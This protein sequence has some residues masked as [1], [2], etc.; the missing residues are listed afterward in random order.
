MQKYLTLFLLALGFLACNKNN[1]ETYIET[2]PTIYSSAEW[3]SGPVRLFTKSGEI[4]DNSTIAELIQ[5]RDVGKQLYFGT[6]GIDSFTYQ[7]RTIRSDS[8]WFYMMGVPYKCRMIQSWNARLLI[9]RDTIGFYANN[10]YEWSPYLMQVRNGFSNYPPLYEM[11]SDGAFPKYRVQPVF[12][13]QRTNTGMEA[14]F[15]NSVLIQP[16]WMPVV[17][18]YV[19]TLNANGYSQLAENDTLLIQERVLVM[20]KRNW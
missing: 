7:L 1:H 16:N 12:P 18:N 11:L 13:M 17:Q 8:V 3:R 4:T 19:T 6:Q 5:R 2:F 15:I 10:S 14:T 9:S 20:K